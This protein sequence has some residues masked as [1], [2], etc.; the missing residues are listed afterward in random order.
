V[1]KA[2]R[3]ALT[4]ALS[5]ELARR[6][7]EV[8]RNEAGATP[9]ETFKAHE[10]EQ[11]ELGEATVSSVLA[12]MFHEKCAYCEGDEGNEIEHHWPKKPHPRLNQN[13]GTPARMFL[14]ENL[15]LAC[16]MCNGF[17]C[18]GA[19]MRWDA[20]GRPLL[21]DPSA[22]GDDPLC[23]FTI[24]VVDTESFKT[25]WIDPSSELNPDALARATYTVKR[26][27]LNQRSALV[28]KRARSIK[29]FN[30]LIQFVRVFGPDGAPP[31]GQSLRQAF[32][33]FFDPR[34]PHLAPVRQVLRRDPDLRRELLDLMP[35]LTDL[36]AS[37]D[38]P[39]DD[40]TAVHR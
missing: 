7:G 24:Q 17:E 6:Q 3:P 15:V 29:D 26:L 28:R 27:K 32:I 18:K 38:R 37:W 9:W 12:S 33:D 34:S 4:P 25:G 8:D 36:L 35:E 13:R 14:W 1:L 19:H 40:C 30:R 10:R 11:K 20:T 23:H 2:S 16:H 5:A 31:G 39:P 21:L 22:A